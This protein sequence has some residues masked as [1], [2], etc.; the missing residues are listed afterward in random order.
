M[1]RRYELNPV[2][3]LLVIRNGTATDWPSICKEFGVSPSAMRTDNYY[4]RHWL[5]MFREA[6]LIIDS[7][8]SIDEYDENDQR[9]IEISPSWEKIQSA[10]GISLSQLA[11]WEP[12]KSMAIRPFFG[13]PTT[14]STSSDIFVLMP[15]AEALKPVYQ[16]HIAKV[17]ESL[18][19]KAV[20]GDDFFTAHSIM[21][22]IWNAVC[23]AR[24]VIADCTNRNPNVFYEIGL[25]HAIGK[26]VILITQNKDD[27]PFDLRHLRYIDY[28]YT[29]R[30]MIEFENRLEMT[31]RAELLGRQ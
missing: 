11:N 9:K 4:L 22:D 29:P 16:D 14:P 23:N 17:A 10:L 15:F 18:K 19:L 12:K 27:V 25:A 3:V 5:K 1:N 21:S 24:L 26:R 2:N 13:L 8:N 30:G 31:I 7:G 20:R 6:G 28:E